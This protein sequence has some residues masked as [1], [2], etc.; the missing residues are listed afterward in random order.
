MFQPVILTKPLPL[1]GGQR[2]R[3]W[4][5]WWGQLANVADLGTTVTGLAMGGREVGFVPAFLIGRGYPGVVVIVVIKIAAALTIWGLWRAAG[6]PRQTSAGRI[7]VL[8]GLGGMAV[9]AGLLTWAVVH[10]V[11]VLMGL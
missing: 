1:G 5:A 7:G 4:L 9:L 6:A 8:S 2:L 10:N 3:A 11:A